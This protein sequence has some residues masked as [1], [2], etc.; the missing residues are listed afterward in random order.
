MKCLWML[1]IWFEFSQT[2]RTRN[3]TVCEAFKGNTLDNFLFFVH[4]CKVV[5]VMRVCSLNL[6]V[7]YICG[8]WRQHEVKNLSDG[9]VCVA[10]F[11][12]VSSFHHWLEVVV[13]QHRL[14]LLGFESDKKKDSLRG[15]VMDPT[16]LLPLRRGACF[17]ILAE[18]SV[19]H[20]HLRSVLN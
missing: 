2:T 16:R 8:I 6:L 18:E 17:Q 19:D 7:N 11:T 12:L 3:L 1:L 10:D 15:S 20:I 14:L 9:F 5:H 13:L 4:S